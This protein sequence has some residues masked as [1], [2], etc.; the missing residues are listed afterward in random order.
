MKRL[1]QGISTVEVN[2][3]LNARRTWNHH[4]AGLMRSVQIWQ[5]VGLA[6]LLIAAT[7]VAGIIAIGSQSKFIPL[8]FQQDA[9]GN[10]ISVTRADKIQE[11]SVDDM[12]TAAVQ[13]IENIRLVTPDVDLQRKA[14][15]QV[16][17]YL[18]G[19]DAA[20]AKVNQFYQKDK[21]S[22][23][24]VRAG[25][26]TVSVEVRSILQQSENT[27]Q[28]EWTETTRTR[29]GEL[30]AKPVLMKALVTIYQNN[31]SLDASNPTLLRNPHLILVRDF[32]WSKEIKSGV[33]S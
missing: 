23:P 30:K 27:W 26:E 21:E 17:A 22:N 8:V 1:T 4:M 3:Y 9:N 6:S 33:Q 2:P 11:A 10:T 20:V 15:L 25:T 16:Y 13:F 5:A 14:V 12:R 28:I 29:D 18:D 31:A 19:S 32:S 24:F 7:A